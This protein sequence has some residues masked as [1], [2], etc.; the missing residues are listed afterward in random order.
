MLSFV[1]LYTLFVCF[2]VFHVE[3]RKMA[4]LAVLCFRRINTRRR[5]GEP[6]KAP[7]LWAKIAYKRR[8][9]RR[10]EGAGRES[11]R[12]GYQT[13]VKRRGT[14]VYRIPLGEISK[15]AKSPFCDFLPV[16]VILLL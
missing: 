5:H 9:N 4:F 16:S 7:I 8:E 2:Q 12:R 1:A 14:T 15:P 6:E 3:R 10:T 11:G 13:G